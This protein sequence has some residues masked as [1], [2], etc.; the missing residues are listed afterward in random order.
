MACYRF[1]DALAV[2]VEVREE[3][4]IQSADSALATSTTGPSV[5]VPVRPR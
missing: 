4:P 5:R 2:R 1:Y 3:R